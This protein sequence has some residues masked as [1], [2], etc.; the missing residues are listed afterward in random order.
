MRPRLPLPTAGLGALFAAAIATVTASSTALAATPLEEGDDLVELCELGAPALEAEEP[1]V[2]AQYHERRR[3][4]V[5]QV[6]ESTLPVKDEGL[7]RYDRVT[8]LLTVSGFREYQPTPGAPAIRFRNECFLS[9]EFDEEQAH[10]RMAQIRMGTVEVRIGY[11]V[12]ARKDYDEHFCPAAEEDDGPA[13]LQVHLLY[14]RLID[15]ER[16]GQERV[17]DTYQTKEGRRWAL[18]KSAHLLDVAR[19]SVPEV[20][21]SHLQ[22]RPEGKRWEDD[23]ESDASQESLQQLETELRPSIERAVYPCYIRATTVNTSV[24]GAL[25][26]EVPV[27]ETSQ[28]GIAFLMD[29]MRDAGIRDCVME[30]LSGLDVVSENV[31]IDGVDA[32]KA[33]ILMRRR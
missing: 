27:T 25:V 20:E 23:F 8:G 3:Q 12:V 11:Q 30:R 31:E 21:V 18:R 28:Q 26:V 2:H 7:L 32:F 24:Q 33:T 5:H 13:Q 9:F 16:G 29:T 15:K 22:W 6:Y 17:I 14:A 10:D 19:P 1:A 4:A